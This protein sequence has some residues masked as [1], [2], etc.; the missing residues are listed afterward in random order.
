MKK[1]AV[2]LLPGLFALVLAATP[3]ISSFT[4]AAIAAPTQ[5][6]DAGTKANRLNLTDAQKAQMKQIR[7]TTRQKIDAVLTPEQRQLRDTARQNR[8]RPNLNLSADQ[9]AQIKAIRDQ[10]R[11]QMDALLTP[12][13][14]QLRDQLRQQHQK[15]HHK[16]NAAQPSSQQ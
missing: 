6:R 13:Q 7:D 12:E 5:T 14:R 11:S 10:A 15:N 3:V 1:N 9:K 4:N 2:F 16:Q 8:Q